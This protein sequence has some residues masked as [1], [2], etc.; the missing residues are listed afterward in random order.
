MKARFEDVVFV[1]YLDHV[2]YSRAPALAMAPQSRETIGWLIYECNEYV[3][4]SWD[5]D[6]GTP[7]L[8]GGDPKATG[9][10]LLKSDILDLR[11]LKDALELGLN[12]RKTTHRNEYALR[13]TER[14]TQDAGR[15]ST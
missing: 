11:P 12:P 7:T 9:L 5:R 4:I 6:A 2:Q 10:V 1:H 13:K 15:T 3:T 14:K 8:R